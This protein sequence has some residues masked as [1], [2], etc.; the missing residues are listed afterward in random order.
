M[1]VW[2][3]GRC[4]GAQNFEVLEVPRSKK[5]KD[6][7][8]P[9]SFDFRSDPHPASVFFAEVYLAVDPPGLLQASSEPLS[10]VALKESEALRANGGTPNERP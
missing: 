4:W 2:G 8:E 3:A 10:D 1:P 9:S 5:H 7:V 6:Q